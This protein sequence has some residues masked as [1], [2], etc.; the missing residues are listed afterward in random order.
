MPIGRL[1]SDLTV[2]DLLGN[3]IPGAIFL[4][5]VSVLLPAD[6]FSEILSAPVNGI[7]LLFIV[8][9]SVG[10]LLQSY[11]ARAIGKRESFKNT[12]IYIQ[13][14]EG[15]FSPSELDFDNYPTRY[16]RLHD[17]YTWIGGQSR[18][19]EDIEADL[20]REFTEEI[21]DEGI[22]SGSIRSTI[23]RGV[24]RFL[25][26]HVEALLLIRIKRDRP[27]LGNIHLTSRVWKICIERYQLNDIDENRGDFYSDLLHLI[28]SDL[29]RLETSP[30]ALRFQAIRNFH[31]GLWIAFYF[32]TVL[33]TVSWLGQLLSGV[34]NPIYGI[35]G[36]T[37]WTP[38]IEELWN[39]TP[40][41]ILGTAVTSYLFWELTEEYEEEFIEYLLVDFLTAYQPQQ[42]SDDVEKTAGSGPVTQLL[43]K[44]ME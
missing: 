31:R 26:A 9:F 30:R 4:A 39:P 36:V 44:I 11:S 13:S 40:L 41:L 42:Q 6:R 27:L 43:S 21:D 24:A 15:K 7:L 22:L 12:I 2:F 29:E 1:F 32:I 34:L 8:G 17:I 16:P 33:L 25:R 3:F 5:G 10:H 20:E 14:F 35:V 18:T 38:V 37:P 28:S 23:R 19:I